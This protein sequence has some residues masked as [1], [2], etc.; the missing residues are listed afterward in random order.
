MDTVSTSLL[1]C[2]LN[3]YCARALNAAAALCQTW[4]QSEITLIFTETES[5]P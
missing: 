2:R 4:A 3:P 5:Q 1:L